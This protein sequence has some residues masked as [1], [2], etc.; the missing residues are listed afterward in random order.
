MLLH[1]N[2]VHSGPLDQVGV[3]VYDSPVEYRDAF[4]PHPDQD[5]APFLAEDIFFDRAKLTPEQAANV[6]AQYDGGILYV[7]SLLHGLFERMKRLGIY[8]DTLIIVTSD[9]GESLGDHGT[10]A[11]HGR[12]WENGIHVPLLVKLPRSD[13]RRTEWTGAEFDSKVQL[14]DVAP[15][16][17]RIAG[18]P[19]PSTFQ[20]QDFTLLRERPVIASRGASAVL[21]QD[22]HKLWV[23]SLVERKALLFNLSDDPE[24]AHSIH[25][26]RPELVQSM[27]RQLYDI[28]MRQ[29]ELSRQIHDRDRDQVD[30]DSEIK[31]ELRALGYLNGPA[32]AGRKKR[33][34]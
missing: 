25:E 31:M 2:A 29:K 18:V 16:V 24:E 4:L 33:D 28:I 23:Q 6:V 32:P 19:G 14:V 20:G 30:L 22:P 3:P 34:G 7:D 8:E 27:G 10:F 1:T 21:I 17:A 26:E 11:T 13:P 15:A 12:F 5:T 9:H